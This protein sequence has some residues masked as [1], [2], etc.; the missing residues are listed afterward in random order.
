VGQSKVGAWVKFALASTTQRKKIIIM[1][2]GDSRRAFLEFLRNLTPQILFLTLSLIVGSKLDLTKFRLD[3][4]GVGNAFPFV[5]CLLIF[6]GATMANVTLFVDAAITSNEKL[7]ME[8]SEIKAKGL[9]SHRLTW[10]LLCA[11]WEHN[12]PAFFQLAMSLLIAEFAFVAV[13]VIA[14]QGALASPL[15]QR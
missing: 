15:L 4:V 9:K 14:I 3:S 5:L 13:F 7:D 8:V 12:K 2:F 1:F 11:A 10:A 6:F